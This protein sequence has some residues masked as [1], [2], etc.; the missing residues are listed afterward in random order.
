MAVP[1]GVPHDAPEARYDTETYGNFLFSSLKPCIRCG[2]VFKGCV[3]DECFYQPLEFSGK[4]AARCVP[5][6]VAGTSCVQ[7]PNPE[8]K[9]VATLGGICAKKFVTRVVKTEPGENLEGCLKALAAAF[10]DI[11]LA[12]GD[13]IVSTVTDE[14]WRMAEA[15]SA[16]MDDD[17]FQRA[18]SRRDGWWSPHVRKCR[19]PCLMPWRARCAKRSQP[20]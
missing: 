17:R 1:D 13:D 18:A 6:W 2:S 9:H 11:P 7:K 16:H 19:G 5:C 8:K 15:R 3:C 20:Y 4:I 10:P 14:Y 12:H